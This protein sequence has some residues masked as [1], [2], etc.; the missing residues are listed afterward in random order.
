MGDTNI[1]LKSGHLKI[2]VL[3]RVS[4]LKGNGKAGKIWSHF[5]IFYTGVCWE[6]KINWFPGFQR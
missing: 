4:I 2:L 6:K 1:S 3:L 5:S